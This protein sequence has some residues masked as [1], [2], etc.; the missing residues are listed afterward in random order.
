VEKP[1]LGFFSYAPVPE[2]SPWYLEQFGLPHI[3]AIAVL[4]A[5]VGLV[6]AGRK[7]LAAWTGEARLRLVAT[8]V[9][10]VF[11]ISLH[12]IIWIERGWV[13][14]VANTI[15]LDLCAISLWL[16][17][18]LNATGRRWVF[19]LLYFWGWGAVA[20]F[21]FANTEGAS[22]NTWHYYQYFIVHGFILLTMT[23]FAAVKD[24]RPDLKSL[25]RAMGV[26]LPLSVGIRFFDLAFQDP[27]WRFNFS[28][29][30]SPPDV[31]TPLDAFGS[32]WGYY[33][34]F[35]GLVA[36]IFVLVALPWAFSARFWRRREG[37]A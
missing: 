34:A 7:R 3:A 27:P 5:L 19:D 15:P 35:A 32:G 23:W 1:A 26:L 14:F 24:W 30:V 31:G 17:V 2:T 13:Q 16:S 20:S 10:L 36:V 37:R 22:W 29:L 25:G 12:V 8:L 33:F 6:I 21:L 11:E 4:L 28:Y 18:V 9:T